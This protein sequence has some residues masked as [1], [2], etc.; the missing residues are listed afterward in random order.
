M[1][2]QITRAWAVTFY[3]GSLKGHCLSRYWANNRGLGDHP[4]PTMLFQTRREARDWLRDRK[5]KELQS[6]YASF[7]YFLDCKVVHVV[8]D[9]REI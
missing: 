1:K 6:N 9:I 8:I 7:R 5:N 4:L 2:T 3:R